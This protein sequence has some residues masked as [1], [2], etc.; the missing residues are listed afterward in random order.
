MVFTGRDSSFTSA[1][2]TSTAMREA[3]IFCRGLIMG[4]R[5][6]IASASTPTPTAAQFTVEKVRTTSPSFSM[7]ST[8]A[9]VKVRPKKSLS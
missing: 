9:W 8:G 3:G 7:V 2:V 4:H 1:A 5:H 6:R